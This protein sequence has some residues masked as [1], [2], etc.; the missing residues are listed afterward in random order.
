MFCAI[1][2]TK[3]L[4]FIWKIIV[5]MFS[6]QVAFVLLA[7]VCAVLGAP[8]NKEPVPIISQESDIQPDGTFKWSFESGDGTKAEQSGQPKQVEQETPLVYQGSASWTDNEGT[9]HQLTYIADENGYQPQSPDIPVAPEIP[10]AIQRAL[11]YNAAHP[12]QDGEK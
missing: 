5:R 11:E 4:Q 9:Q 10:A 3:Q 8:Q 6:C 1:I 12:E 7:A 2:S